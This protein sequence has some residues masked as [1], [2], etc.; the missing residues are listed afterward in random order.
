M[1]LG[2]L[3]NTDKNLNDVIGIAK[4]AAGKG[5]E[6]QVFA[7]DMGTKLL[8]QSSF[9]DLRNVKGVSMAFCD[10]SSKNVGAKTE[11]MPAEIKRSDQW[12][13]SKMHNTSEK[14]II[15]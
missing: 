14:V 6:V 4:S 13:N 8:E 12:Q 7:M 5:H 2:I 11:N 15:L 9:L 1:K 3:V 10:F